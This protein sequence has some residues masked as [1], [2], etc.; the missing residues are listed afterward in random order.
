[1]AS[2]DARP[3]HRSPHSVEED[4]TERQAQEIADLKLEREQ[5]REERQHDGPKK[6][7]AIK[8]ASQTLPPSKNSLTL[9][10]DEVAL[11]AVKPKNKS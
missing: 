3:S 5:A 6:T 10:N 11:A 9:V 7:C 1:M 4:E 2:T 8:T